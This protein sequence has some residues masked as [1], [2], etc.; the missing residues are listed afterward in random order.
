[1]ARVDAIRKIRST[2]QTYDRWRR[3][4]ACVRQWSE[5][6]GE[7]GMGTDQLKELKRLRKENERRRAAVSNLTP[8]TLIQTEAAKGHFIRPLSLGQWR[9]MVSTLPSPRLHRPCASSTP[10]VRASSLPGALEQAIGQV[11]NHYYHR[12][13]HVSI[14]NVTPADAYFGPALQLLEERGRIKEETLKMRRLH[15]QAQAA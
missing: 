10:S 7:C 1:V 6:D 3:Q 11:V 14:G 4:R 12:R 2:E 9:S 5:D 13:C 8:D 15:N